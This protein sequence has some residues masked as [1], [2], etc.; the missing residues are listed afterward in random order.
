MPP[1]PRPDATRRLDGTVG[2]GLVLITIGV[3]LTLDNLDI[4]SASE[5]L[6][7]WWP[8]VVVAV[9]LWAAVT[10]SAVLGVL[11]AAVGGLLLLSTQEV[12]TVGVGRLVVPGVLVVVGGTLLQAGRRVR[13]AQV[14]LV[15][16]LGR[17]AAEGVAGATGPAP[18]ATAI[19]GDARLV[20]D[21]VVPAGGRV[22]VSATSVLGDVRIE[23]PAG[24]RL[25]D[26]VTRVLGDVRLPASS[27]P[28]SDDAPVV[29]LHGVVL[30]GDVRVTER[31]GSG[32]AA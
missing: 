30:L 20:V 28:R 11:V 15:D 1:P 16:A 8:V 17:S 7:G 18:A 19:F 14:T 6:A 29:E 23:V 21:D 4:V 5:L 3:V 13:T 32:G 10:G 2:F 27:A 25:E 31:A 26:H 12:V 24:W 22:L 9:G